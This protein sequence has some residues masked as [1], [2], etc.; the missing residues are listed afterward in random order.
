M[1]SHSLFIA[2]VVFDDHDLPI[3]DDDVS[4]LHSKKIRTFA[5]REPAK[6]LN[7]AQICGSFFLGNLKTPH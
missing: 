7:D 5:P 1:Y 4:L 2:P 3:G 6:P